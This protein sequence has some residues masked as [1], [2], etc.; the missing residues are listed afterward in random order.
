MKKVVSFVLTV[1]CLLALAGCGGGA[2]KTEAPAPNAPAAELKIL[3]V[4][5]DADY[6][7]FEFYQEKSKTFTGFD[8]EMMNM[9]A[10]QIGYDR[11]EFHD[12]EFNN[13]FAAVNDKQVDAVI[14]CINITDERSKLVD[15]T[16]PYLDSG[17]VVVGPSGPETSSTKTVKNKRIAAETGTLPAKLAKTFTN[18]VLECSVAEETLKL[19][20]DKKADFAILDSYTA[21]F[22]VS[23]NYKGKLIIVQELHNEKDKGMAIA[24]AKGNTALKEKLN[25]GL[26]QYRTGAH[27]Q[28]LRNS[29]FGKLK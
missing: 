24:V 3:R 25:E 27:F 26:K 13:L 29:Y 8:I 18:D 5:T 14:S 4:G 20:V 19:I 23:H 28:Q 2:K 6:P 22:Y 9:L 12:I 17:M 7:P 15:F 11:V 16:D 1:I 21:K 10:R